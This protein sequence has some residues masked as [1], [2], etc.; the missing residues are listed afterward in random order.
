M[1]KYKSS[2]G[3]SVKRFFRFQWFWNL[4]RNARLA[5]ILIAVLVISGIIAFSITNSPDVKTVDEET[6]SID[7]ADV[8]TARLSYFEGTV[9]ASK[10]N[11]DN[12]EKVTQNQELQQ[13]TRLRTVGA[14]AK[15]VAAFKDE[16][17]LRVDGSSEIELTTL[18]TERVEVRQ[19]NGYT[20][21]R[22][23]PD[24]DREFIVRTKNA[25]FEADGTAFRTLTTGDEEGVE[26]YENQVSETVTNK[27]ASSGER[28]IITV[29]R[30]DVSSEVE[31]INLNDVKENEFISWNRQRDLDNDLFKDNLGYLSDF[32]GPEINVTSPEPGST[33]TI[34]E[35]SEPSI[36]FEGTAENG[37]QLTV[38]SKSVNGSQ[39]VSVDVVEGAFI[40]SGVQASVGNSVFE[41]IAR[42]R[43]GNETRKSVSYTVV[44]EASTLEQGIELSASQ[45]GD[46]IDLT[47]NVS[48]ITANDGYYV[49]YDTKKGPVYPDSQSKKSTQ[50]KLS[51]DSNEL[52]SGQTYY[53]RV[54]RYLKNT[55]TCDNYSNE[56]KLTIN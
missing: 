27:E 1:G 55:D 6:A 35:G 38:E 31:A 10:D 15:A 39:P 41:F 47:W 54:C 8:T 40:S 52:N 46:K 33:I 20:F 16:S 37:S 28:I 45:S 48:G 49:S 24:D 4:S 7:T 13:G 44:R 25:Q 21:A 42:D 53:F 11:G 50:T 14:S 29:D 36:V 32:D 56:S 34:A 19:D 51:I 26:V 30:G 17:E 9:E 5:I 22:L 2:G 12:W 3:S 23:L 43:R 18:T